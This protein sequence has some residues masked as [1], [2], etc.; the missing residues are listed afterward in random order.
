MFEGADFKMN[1][2]RGW[3][4]LVIAAALALAAFHYSQF[5]QNPRPRW[6]GLVHDRSGHYEFAQK[7][8][9]AVRQADPWTFFSTLEKA[10]VWP[11]VHG[12]CAAAV[13]AVGGIDYRLAVLPSL[14][15]WV[16]TAVFG[17]LLVR[18]ISASNGTAA[19]VIAATMI[20]ASPAH[21][22]HALDIMLESLGAAFTAMAMYFYA[23]AKQNPSRP[24]WR[25]LAITLTVLFFEKYNYWLLVV[26]A[27]TAA[28][29]AGWRASE[30]MRAGGFFTRIE[31]RRVLRA[32]AREP[33]TWVFCTLVVVTV[34]IF[35]FRPGPL[36]SGGKI[37][38]LYPPNNLVTLTYAVLFFRVLKSYRMMP[39]TVPGQRQLL[40]WHCLPIAASFLLPRRLSAF[41]GYI[42]P[43][44]TGRQP[45]PPVMEAAANYIQSVCV[46]YHSA[47]WSAL[48]AALLFLLALVIYRRMLAGGL[49]VLL[50]VL[51]S[52]ALT[53]V[54]PLQGSRFLHTWIPAFW[55]IGAAGLATCLGGAAR[56]RPLLAL[57]ASGAV[58][59]A[60]AADLV[61]PGHAPGTGS[62]ETTSLLDITDTYLPE[63]G[64]ERRVSIFSTVPCTQFLLWTYRE[65]Y[66]HSDKLEIPLK[67][68]PLSDEEVRRRLEKWEDASRVDAAILID[69]APDSAHY[70]PIADYSAYRQIGQIISGNPRFHLARQWHLREQGCTIS[71]WRRN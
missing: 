26:F 3:L 2:R 53:L 28:E 14:A 52:A 5:L 54:H 63:L 44:N 6:N 57:G 16:A 33:L 70:V 13:L 30:W 48:I 32:E 66:P 38:S 50:L 4:A 67:D 62:G 27:L 19:G 37:V 68:Y 9:I 60:H 24:A 45:A 10:K 7:M 42:G 1:A 56:L 43:F 22:V 31:W 46:D 35:I 20:L 61:K 55:V 64:G 41:A 40:V 36:Q 65:R 58:V 17:F 23:V 8:A 11:P 12:L 34:A 69:I 18:R 71:M 49:A 21:R 51:I 15:G 25:R 29:L 47:V 39:I 59:L